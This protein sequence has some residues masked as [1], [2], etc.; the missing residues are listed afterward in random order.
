MDY[1]YFLLNFITKEYF[2]KRLFSGEKVR[3]VDYGEHRLN[4]LKVKG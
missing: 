3:N 4:I 2:L 1:C